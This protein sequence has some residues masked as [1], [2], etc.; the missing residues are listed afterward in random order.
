M[1][2]NDLRDFIQTL[3]KAGE[4]LRIDAPVSHDLEIAEITDR[5]SKGPAEQNKALLFTNVRGF[6]M[7]VLINAFGSAK[8]MNMS[9]EV[10]NL[11]NIAD[12]IR[13]LIKPKVP[14][15]FLDKLALVPTLMEVAKFP[16]KLSTSAAPCQ[17]VVI[18]DPSQPMLDKIPIIKCWPED[19]GD[20]VTLG[21]VI[22]RD[23]KNGIRNLGMYRLQKYDNVTTG[24]HWH[25][26]HDGAKAFEERRRESTKHPDD[27]NGKAKAGSG[28]IAPQNAEPPNYGEVFEAQNDPAN[29]G[30]RFEVAIALGCDPAVTYAATAPLPPDIDEFLLAGFLR[31]SPVKLVKC[32]T[33]DLEVPANAEIIIEGY[34]NQNELQ[35]EGPFGDHTGFYS[36]AGMFPVLHVTAVTHRREPIYQTTI[37]G[38][39]PQE[40]CY[41]GKATERIFLPMLQ[42]LV[43]EIVDMNLPWEG[44]FHNCAVIAIDKRYPGHARKVMTAIWGLGQIMFTKFVIIV[45]KDINVQ[46]LSEV[47]LHV[48]G[49][50]D[51]RR[52]TMF[53]DG[54]LD[55]LDHSAPLMGYGSKMGIDATRKWKSEGFMRDWPQP[56][57]MDK[58]VQSLVSAR[59]AEYGL[60]ATTR[61]NKN[62]LLSSSGI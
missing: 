46:N 41:L 42:M 36:L 12:R 14:E 27:T 16:P 58:T 15:N 49:N 9:L 13:V 17:E 8:R 20:F 52:D 23:P 56:L 24:M 19:G 6:E 40:D 21:V 35:L 11:D 43:P 7:P 57:V 32:K 34:V 22:T 28:A 38:K 50:T 26:H 39:P 61:S 48:F 47:A 37:V 18:T 10:E 59:W 30:K 25:K 62:S 4:L 54:P 44:V 53:V 3:E 1:A 33:I 55:I 51:P 2:F 29:P 45:D 5:V 31:Q 60:T